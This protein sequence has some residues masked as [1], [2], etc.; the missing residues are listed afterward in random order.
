MRS[1]SVLMRGLIG[2]GVRTMVTL[3][4]YFDLIAPWCYIGKRR[5]ESAIAKLDGEASVEV[6][7]AAFEINPGIPANGLNRREYRAAKAG[8]WDRA[9]AF[10]AQVTELGRNVGLDFHF[11]RIE[12]TPNTLDVHR[13]VA[14]ARRESRQDQVVEA[15]LQAYFTDGR[16]LSRRDVLIQV[17][18]EAGLDHHRASRIL[19]SDEGKTEVRAQ[20]QSAFDLGVRQVPFFILNGTSKLARVCDTDTLAATFREGAGLPPLPGA[21]HRERYGFKRTSCDCDFCRVYCRHVPGRLDVD[22][23]RRLCPEGTDVF[24]WAETHLQAVTDTPFPRLVPV[25]QENGHCHWYHDGHCSVHGNAP[26]GCAFFDAHMTPAQ[27]KERATA[28]NLA[29]EQDAAAEG[30][31]SAVWQHLSQKGMSRKSGNPFPLGQE[32]QQ[33]RASMEQN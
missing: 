13:V 29:S 10:D 2:T 3:R 7:W 6:E 15:L 9:Q 17:A 26:Y 23:L 32:M 22:D 1:L 12:R 33:I 16:D 8:T 20:T 24:G 18:L 28:A 25:R 27:V 30:L 14:F 4:I 31:Y 11:E 21:R 5:I 19:E